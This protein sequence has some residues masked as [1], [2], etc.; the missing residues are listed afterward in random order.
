MK[1]WKREAKQPPRRGGTEIRPE[2][3]AV[4]RCLGISVV[5]RGIELAEGHVQGG[6]DDEHHDG[7]YAVVAEAA[8]AGL[9]AERFAPVLP[10]EDAGLGFQRFGEDEGGR[11]HD[12]QARD[13]QQELNNDVKPLVAA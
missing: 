6:E 1:D 9:A 7:E 11:N 13:E 5:H 12:D 2:W 8:A 4:A 3:G 10:D